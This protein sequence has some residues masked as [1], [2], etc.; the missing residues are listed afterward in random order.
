MNKYFL[1]T[2]RELI[3]STYFTANVYQGNGYKE[4]FSFMNGNDF[5][6]FNAITNTWE[7]AYKGDIEA[8]VVKSNEL[9]SSHLPLGISKDF[10]RIKSSTQVKAF[11]LKYGSL[12]FGITAFT[13]NNINAFALHNAAPL[14]F[15]STTIE[16]IEVW[17]HCANIVRAITSLYDD[18]QYAYE[19]GDEL[20]LI[21]ENIVGGDGGSL[22]TWHYSEDESISFFLH[23]TQQETDMLSDLDSTEIR[24][25]SLKIGQQ[26]LI[27]AIKPYIN[28]HILI[29]IDTQKN[30]NNPLG[31]NVIEHRYAENLITA[32]FYDLWLLLVDDIPV[33]CCA[34]CNNPFIQKNKR[35]KYC[36]DSCK[37]LFSRNKIKSLAGSPK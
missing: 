16:P 35:R 31:I 14:R 28:G 32:I 33:A 22:A 34:H 36:S 4:I 9:S 30:T 23:C 15:D 21:Y 24:N 6:D 25:S 10:Q 1:G 17:Y 20:E 7:S 5:M 8:F 26:L 12:G 19:A 37:T 18:I 11:A 29:D 3:E 13:P 27:N 2:S